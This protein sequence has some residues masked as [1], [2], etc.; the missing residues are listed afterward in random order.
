MAYRPTYTKKCTIVL[1]DESGRPIVTTAKKMY[2][3]VDKAHA[4]GQV[5]KEDYNN[6]RGEND[7]VAVNWLV[8]V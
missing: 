5:Y 3:G 7:P 4:Y 8:S 6:K 1:L 2:G